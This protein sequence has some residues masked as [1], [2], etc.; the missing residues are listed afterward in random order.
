MKSPWWMKLENE[1]K[2]PQGMEW[3]V[4][5]HPLWIV[6]MNLKYKIIGWFT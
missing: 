4:K 3:D 5:I 2:G 6:Y 1:R